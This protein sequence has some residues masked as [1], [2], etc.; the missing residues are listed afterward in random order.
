MLSVQH[1]VATGRVAAAGVYLV[2][3]L[4]CH[5]RPER[6]FTLVDL[7]LPVCARCTGIYTGAT[8]GAFCALLIGAGASI[9][10]WRQALIAAVVPTLLTLFLEHGAGMVITNIARALA[11]IPI[12]I[13]T[14]WI[15]AAALSGD[16]R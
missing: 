16:L 3:S 11:A 4:V 10:R 14:G 5:Q 6:S 2:G 1:T 13:A 15:V 8:L 9:G 12:G 7:H